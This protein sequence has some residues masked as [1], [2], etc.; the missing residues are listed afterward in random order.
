MVTAMNKIDDWSSVYDALADSR[1]DF[2][3]VG[4]I[5]RQTGLAEDRVKELIEQH[6]AEVRQTLSPEREAIFTLAARPMKFREIIA[7]IRT[8]AANSL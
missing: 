1:W 3:T 6:R 7:D 4:G 5:S 8:F 2:R